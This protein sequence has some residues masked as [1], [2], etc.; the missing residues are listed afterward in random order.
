MQ[1]F[2]VV[3]RATPVADD[4][5]HS[6]LGEWTARFGLRRTVR[7]VCSDRIG[8]ACTCGGWCPVLLLPHGAESWSPERRRVVLLHELGH[9][10]RWDWLTQSLAYVVCSLHWFNPLLWLAARRMRIERE[11]ACDDLVLATGS[12]PSVYADALLKIALGLRGASAARGLHRVMHSGFVREVCL[13]FAAVPMARG[14]SL[15]RR[16]TAILDDRRRRGSLSRSS[17]VTGLTL[18]ATIV[19]PV[20]MLQTG[21]AESAPSFS[22]EQVAVIGNPLTEDAPP[23]VRIVKRDGDRVILAEILAPVHGREPTEILHR[24]RSLGQID[25]RVVEG[26][27]TDQETIAWADR[28]RPTDTGTGFRAKSV[29]L[30][31]PRGSRLRLEIAGGVTIQELPREQTDGPAQADKRDH[32]TRITLVGGNLRI[33]DV[34]SVARV[35]AQSSDEAGKLDIAVATRAG[36]ANLQIQT[37]GDADVVVTVDRDAGEPASETNPL[38]GAVRYQYAAPDASGMTAASVKMQ[39]SYDIEVLGDLERRAA[40][41]PPSTAERPRQVT[42]VGGAEDDISAPIIYKDLMLVVSSHEGAAAI[43]FNDES[44]RGVS[45]RYRYESA[46]GQRVLRGDGVLSEHA[47]AGAR[48]GNRVFIEAGPIRLGWSRR[49]ENGG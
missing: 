21:A 19:V 41:R 32:T 24:F 8:M 11:H 3:W 25:G 13:N 15:Q 5:W 31:L 38:H 7:L 12:Q 18:L 34:D 46:S 42:R 45:Y 33:L 39:F 20:A 47:D 1:V 40:N 28:A 23:A 10:K 37:A 16:L 2:R 6:L 30:S 9:I 22:P 29:Q 36:E 49:G 17:V 35:T 48:S 44:E 43:I 14:S 26:R 4:A 27:I